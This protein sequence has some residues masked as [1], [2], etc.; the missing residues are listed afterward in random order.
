MENLRKDFEVEKDNCVNESIADGLRRRQVIALIQTVKLSE[1]KLLI[2]DFNTTKESLM[3]KISQ[4]SK[5]KAE[6]EEKLENRQSL[7]EDI[8][9]IN[10]LEVR[11]DFV[12]VLTMLLADRCGKR[13]SNRQ[14]AT[15]SQILPT[16]AG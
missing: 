9:R 14:T 2:N 1:Q 13:R 3:E 4:F 5:D 15:R 6:L 7:E 8:Q 12:I 11:P 16:R 10:S